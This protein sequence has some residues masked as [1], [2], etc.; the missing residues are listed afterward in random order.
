VWAASG[1][2]T[3]ETALLGRPMIIVYR[4]SW[5]TFMIARWL[6]QVDH[7]G[8]VNLI[9]GERLVPELIQNDANPARI[10]AE[11]RVLL[12]DSQVRSGIIMK[13][14]RL[15]ERLGGPGAADRVADLALGL[16]T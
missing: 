13:L 14:A 7:I 3:L 2:A 5:L 1:T 11:S 8:I 12:D 4:V 15:R 10:M 9:A 6:V 16:M